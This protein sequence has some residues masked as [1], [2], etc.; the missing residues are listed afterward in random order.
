MAKNGV[1]A[2][3]L[4]EFLAPVFGADIPATGIV[5]ALGVAVGLIWLVFW[6]VSR[7]I[8]SGARVREAM[9]R[10]AG[11]RFDG[12]LGPIYRDAASNLIVWTARLARDD[13]GPWRHVD[14]RPGVKAAFA[15]A[16]TGGLY[17]ITLF[18][19]VVYPLVF[20]LGNWF[21]TDRMM[22]G[23]TGF[24]PLEPSASSRLLNVSLL[25]F[26]I[27]IFV[28]FA[29]AAKW[30][31]W[32]YL[33]IGVVAF[34]AAFSAAFAVAFAYAGAGVGAVIVTVSGAMAVALAVAVAVAGAVIAVGAVAV[35]VAG[36]IIGVLAGSVAGGIAGA[37]TGFAGADSFAVGVALLIAFAITLALAVWILLMW[38]GEIF[39]GFQLVYFSLHW[40]F[41]VGL[42]AGLAYGIT[43]IWGA[44]GRVLK[45]LVVFAL[46]PLANAP[47]DW[48][49]IGLTRGLV[50]LGVAQRSSE[51]GR[52]AFGQG[53][54]IIG[55]AIFDLIAA[56]GM[57]FPLTILTTAVIG[58]ANFLVRLGGDATFMPLRDI[59]EGLS[60]PEIPTELYWIFALLLTTLAPTAL[61]LIYALAGVSM[62]VVMTLLWPFK[63]ARA[64]LAHRVSVKDSV[65]DWVVH[66][67]YPTAAATLALALGGALAYA[68]WTAPQV[69]LAAGEIGRALLAT[70]I[71]TAQFFPDY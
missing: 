64:F 69:A 41:F 20:L 55:L 29:T 4:A 66:R 52:V 50:R 12:L 21:V 25:I 49:S 11:G 18:L 13:V 3:S 48:A 46:L 53:W 10:A 35:G 51:S 31:Q 43:A 34:V 36:G 17:Q 63:R 57:M 8:V 56:V 71:W 23:M 2:N 68:L 22:A 62:G 45:L 59:F 67:L 60:G 30:M 33:G 26:A 65:R 19:A 42:A 32:L 9:R 24:L 16:W 61:H 1:D 5:G 27:G 54:R 38:L 58:V 14:R 44:D 28:R 6:R 47:L 40:L 70:A 39:E 7:R 15:G 37:S